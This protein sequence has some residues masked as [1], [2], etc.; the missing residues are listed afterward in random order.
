MVENAWE[1]QTDRSVAS[2]IQTDRSYVLFVGNAAGEMA[3]ACGADGV[4]YAKWDLAR[5]RF[6]GGIAEEPGKT[7]GDADLGIREACTWE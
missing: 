6:N 1:K 3:T 4:T 2:K 7:A 5:V